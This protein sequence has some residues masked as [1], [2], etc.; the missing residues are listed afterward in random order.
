[1]DS[2]RRAYLRVMEKFGR[3]FKLERLDEEGNII[4][5]A[6][7]EGV[8]LEKFMA[9]DPREKLLLLRV[10]LENMYGSEYS[11][12]SIGKAGIVS[13]QGLKNI[14]EMLRGGIRATNIERL[15]RKYNVPIGIITGKTPK[16]EWE[17]GLFIGKPV[18]RDNFHYNYYLQHN[19]NYVLDDTDYSVMFEDNDK[20]KLQEV[21]VEVYIKLRESETGIPITT[22]NIARFKYL[23][24]EVSRLYEI[25]A[26]I[27]NIVAI[28]HDEYMSMYKHIDELYQQ[29]AFAEQRINMHE[30]IDPDKKIQKL[31]N[32]LDNH[33]QKTTRKP[34]SN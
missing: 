9:L 21:D 4:P 13:Y 32:E 7:L 10:W 23:S 11:R 25:I 34:D 31:L 17:K 30:G 19:K 27:M 15:A 22:R 24:E 33:K 1:L 18:D 20:R 16:D 12:V 26:S 3:G 8:H 29:L 6:Y 28:K 14:E 2:A 5:G